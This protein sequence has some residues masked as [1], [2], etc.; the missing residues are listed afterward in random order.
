M[1]LP[2]SVQTLCDESITKHFNVPL[3]FFKLNYTVLGPKVSIGEPRLAV[4]T[5]LAFDGPK[6]VHKTADISSFDWLTTKLPTSAVFVLADQVNTPSLF[7]WN[8]AVIF[9]RLIF[10][11]L[12]QA[13]FTGSLMLEYKQ[14]NTPVLFR[15]QSGFVLQFCLGH[16]SLIQ[17]SSSICGLSR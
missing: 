10:A 5:W 9:S 14:R 13:T 6:S 15:V 3:I 17:P 1:F 16:W 8:S 2:S 11:P 12:V 4:L 7:D